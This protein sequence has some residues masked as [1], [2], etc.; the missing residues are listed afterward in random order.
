MYWQASLIQPDILIF[1][2][3]R[4]R[5]NQPTLQSHTYA[6]MGAE[7]TIAA[8][9][10]TLRDEVLQ[11][12]I[13]AAKTPLTGKSPSKVGEHMSTSAKILDVL[14][15]YRLGSGGQSGTHAD[16]GCLKLLAVIYGHV[17]VR[18]VCLLSFAVA[19]NVQ[20]ALRTCTLAESLFDTGY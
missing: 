9:A 5:P 4:R 20:R 13:Q 10:V 6:I 14:S 1:F 18:L 19:C 7:Q 15:S 11:T 12:F 16:E 3:V 8:E 17:K 2:L